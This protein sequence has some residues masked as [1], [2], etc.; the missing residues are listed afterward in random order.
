M[1]RLTEPEIEQKFSSLDEGW[2]VQGD[3]LNR[4]FMFGDFAKAF[5]WMTKVAAYC[6]QINHHPNW[7]NIYD[8]VAVTIYTHREGGLTTLDFALAS[9]MDELFALPEYRS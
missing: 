3:G 1:A 5:A 8:R 6:E 4:V 2:V 9:K 7:K